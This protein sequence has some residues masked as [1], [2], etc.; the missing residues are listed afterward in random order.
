VVAGIAILVISLG[1]ILAGRG[2]TQT[3][4][5]M[6]AF[7]T[8]RGRVTAREV[9]MMAGLSPEGRW[10]QGGNY[11]PKVTYDYTVD[12]ATYTSDRTSYAHR[13]LRRSLAEQQ[14]AAIPD[15]VDVYYNPAAP[16]E[17]YLEKHTTALGRYLI[18]GG[19]VGVLFA[20]ILVLGSV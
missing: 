10:G 16:E 20:L 12:G 11:R 14:L 15:D 3:A 4:R 6:R 1:A 5:K 7:V 13:G 8:T 9:V 19:G 2:Y 17:A 18:V